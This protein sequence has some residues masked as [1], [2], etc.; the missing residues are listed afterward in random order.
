MHNVD[1]VI[2]R[3]EERGLRG[4]CPAIACMSHSS[5]IFG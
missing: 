3:D 1:A 4:L 2:E 5:A